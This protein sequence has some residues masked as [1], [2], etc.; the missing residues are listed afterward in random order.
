MSF[1]NVSSRLYRRDGVIAG[2]AQGLAD[3]MGIDVILVRLALILVSCLGGTGVLFYLVYWAIVPR[4]ESIVLEPAVLD[5]L[6]KR[7][8]RRTVTDKKISGVCAGLARGWN[9]DP[10]VIRF[11]ALALLCASFGSALLVY[12]VAA[13]VMPGTSSAIA[14]PLVA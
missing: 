1:D 4:R 6:G 12:L 3:R 5:A 2:V 14:G 8:F 7:T 11:V 13:L 9:I 10:A